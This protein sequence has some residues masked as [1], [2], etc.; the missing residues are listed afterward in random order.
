MCDNQIVLTAEEKV[1]ILKRRAKLEKKSLSNV[2]LKDVLKSYPTLKQMLK[3]LQPPAIGQAFE[4]TR[5]GFFSPALVDGKLFLYENYSSEKYVYKV[6]NINVYHFNGLK[7]FLGKKAYLDEEQASDWYF[8]DRY[9]SCAVSLIVLNGRVIFV[10][11]TIFGKGLPRITYPLSKRKED[12]RTLAVVSTDRSFYL[13][14][15]YDCVKELYDFVLNDID[16]HF[17][18]FSRRANKL[19]A[20]RKWFADDKKIIQ[21]LKLSDDVENFIKLLEKE[22]GK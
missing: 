2:P 11:L 21:S 8:T 20:F 16:Y 10:R 22:G 12:A 15:Y 14:F 9:K 7:T 19:L 13:D 1:L 4:E 18:G 3:L 5:Y 6:D 17:K